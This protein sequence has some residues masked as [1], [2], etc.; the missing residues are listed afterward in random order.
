VRSSY[1][2]GSPWHGF[3]DRLTI[4]FRGQPATLYNFK[5]REP[6]LAPNTVSLALGNAHVDPLQNNQVVRA[7]LP[8]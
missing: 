5:V 6:G 8:T 2:F 1:S 7:S 4:G 3:G